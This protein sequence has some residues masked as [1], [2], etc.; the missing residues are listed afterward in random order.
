MLELNIPNFCSTYFVK[1]SHP[2]Q[3]PS[4]SFTVFTNYFEAMEK[5]PGDL[6]IQ[7]ALQIAM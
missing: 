4:V 6:V 3:F 1:Q 2:T 7:I 5:E